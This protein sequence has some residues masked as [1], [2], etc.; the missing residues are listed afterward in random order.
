M[1]SEGGMIRAYRPDIRA[2][3]RPT[4]LLSILHRS[5]FVALVDLGKA[6]LCKGSIEDGGSQTKRMFAGEVKRICP[7]PEQMN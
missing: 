7:R 3:P 5:S 2:T 6:A 4:H 1:P